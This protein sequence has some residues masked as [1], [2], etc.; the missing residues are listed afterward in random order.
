MTPPSTKKILGL[1]ARNMS[2]ELKAHPVWPAAI[3]TFKDAF[4]GKL[5]KDDRT[6]KTDTQVRY[7]ALSPTAMYLLTIVQPSSPCAESTATEM[8]AE[9]MKLETKTVVISTASANT[10]DRI[11]SFG[12]EQDDIDTLSKLVGPVNVN[13]IL[14]RFDPRNK[15]A[16]NKGL[17]GAY[18]RPLT[19]SNDQIAVKNVIGKIFGSRIWHSVNYETDQVWV[20][21]PHSLPRDDVPKHKAQFKKDKLLLAQRQAVQRSVA[22]E[23]AEDAEQTGTDGGFSQT[24]TAGWVALV[25]DNTAKLI[26]SRTPEG[27]EATRLERETSAAEAKANP[28][29]PKVY[30]CTF[31]ATGSSKKVPEAVEPV[32]SA[33]AIVGVPPHLRARHVKER[34]EQE[35]AVAASERLSTPHL[36][37]SL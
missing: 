1:L 22:Q 11:E 35:A 23:N 18:T 33:G 20:G 15:G 14:A 10:Q 13:R 25:A 28:K 5:Y 32:R 4:T 36:S 7:L 2:R 24:G 16:F 26:A 27:Y 12:I 9:D 19:S 3:G 31:K 37:L 17:G 34:L 30:D 29:P 8:P 21:V 6:V